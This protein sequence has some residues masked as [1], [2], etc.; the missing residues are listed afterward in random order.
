MMLTPERLTEME[1]EACQAEKR[2]K[3]NSRLQVWQL[4]IGLIGAFGLASIQA[5]AVVYV[6]CLYPLLAACIARHVG[7]SEGILKQLKAY[8]LKVEYGCDYSGY[9]TFNKASK[10]VGSGNHM[11]A[12]RDAILLTDLLAA[13]VVEV[14]LLADGWLWLAV[15]MAMVVSVVMIVTCHW[16]REG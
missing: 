16:L 15:M 11:R 12:L 3:M 6:V 1:Y 9:E 10:R 4:L 14:R 2:D 7:H 8:L 13:A 5:G